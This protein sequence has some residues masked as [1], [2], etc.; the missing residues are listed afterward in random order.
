MNRRCTLL[1]APFG[2][3]KL[4]IRWMHLHNILYKILSGFREHDFAKCLLRENVECYQ[5]N[6]IFRAHDYLLVQ[7]GF[8]ISVVKILLPLHSRLDSI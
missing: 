8:D 7:C 6:S 3:Y 5:N 2:M 4:Y 1:D